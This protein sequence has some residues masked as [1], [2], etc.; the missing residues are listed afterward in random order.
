MYTN[1]MTCVRGSRLT[2]EIPQDQPIHQVENTVPKTSKMEKNKRTRTYQPSK[3]G[4]PM[5]VTSTNNDNSSTRKN[6]INKMRYIEYKSLEKIDYQKHTFTNI[7]NN[8]NYYQH[9]G[10]RNGTGNVPRGREV[11]TYQQDEITNGGE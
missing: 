5:T 4:L 9:S 7:E 8:N 1:T 10:K 11:Q 3:H 2:V 6:N